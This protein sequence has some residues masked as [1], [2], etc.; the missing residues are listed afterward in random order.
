[1]KLFFALLTVLLVGI[2]TLAGC[3]TT[4]STP[5]AAVSSNSSA[6]QVNTVAL[7]A[8]APAFT[9][10]TITDDVGRTV[11]IKSIPQRII[12]L[13]PSNTEMVYALGLQDSLVGVTTYDNYPPEAKDKPQVSGFSDVDIEK[14]VSLQPD[15]V[16]AADIH[17][18]E[19][20]P[21]LEKL[22]ISV[23]V[24]RPSTIDDVLNEL[25]LLGK[26]SGKTDQAAAL[27]ATLKQRV[28]AI[29]DNVSQLATAKPRIL[30]V[31]WY[32]PIWT[33]G[34]DTMIGDLFSK[35]GANNIANDISG[36]ATISLETAIQ[37]NPQIIL[38]MSSMG[39]Q[40]E[41]LNYINSEPRFQS[42]DAVK[43]KQVFEIDA[44]IFGRTTPRIVDGLETLAKMVH[45]ELNK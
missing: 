29:M 27:V 19:V 28:K 6:V 24:I 22:G 4:A 36:Y 9:G 45:P 16:L 17:R 34:D 11:V 30:Y 42:T 12:S 23:V 26:I 43:N 35:A 13:A 7:A 3:Q 32:D 38:V 33:A 40:N 1:M 20:V 44:D 14:I 41:S 31:A 10:I 18:A 8:S 37:R 39:D 21:A 2:L 15:L 5:P 25:T